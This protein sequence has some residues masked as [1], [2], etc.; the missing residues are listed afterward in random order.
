LANI[1]KGLVRKAAG[2]FFVVFCGFTL[3]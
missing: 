3:N 2:L 1:A